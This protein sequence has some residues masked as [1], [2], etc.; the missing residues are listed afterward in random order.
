M[1]G[2]LRSPLPDSWRIVS[3]LWKPFRNSGRRGNLTRFG[4]QFWPYLKSL[5]IAQILYNLCTI[6]IRGI[7]VR[8]ISLKEIYKNLESHYFLIWNNSATSPMKLW[9]TML[10][11]IHLWRFQRINWSFCFGLWRLL[12]P[13]RPPTLP[14]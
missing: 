14:Q 10:S 7:T 5:K 4:T 6:L 13:Q 2:W 1:K 8:F 3:C 9:M 11:W 12:S